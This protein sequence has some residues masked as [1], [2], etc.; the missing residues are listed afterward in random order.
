MEKFV[1]L[2]EVER[3]SKLTDSDVSLHTNPSEFEFACY[4]KA[5]KA[6]LVLCLR[7]ASEE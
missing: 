6:L 5:T 4:T 3:F 2:S 7:A 1:L